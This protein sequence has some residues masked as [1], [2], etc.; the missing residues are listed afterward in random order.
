MSHTETKMVT[1]RPHK[2]TVRVTE[3]QTVKW[4]MSV[5]LVKRSYE[6]TSEKY[7]AI[8]CLS[9]ILAWILGS[10]EVRQVLLLAFD[11]SLSVRKVITFFSHT[12]NTCTEE[13]QKEKIN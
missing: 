10:I 6:F 8:K 9:A 11:V 7:N 2:D 1:P 13:V 4:I 5:S 12:K 3:L